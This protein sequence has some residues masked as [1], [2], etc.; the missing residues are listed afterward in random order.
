MNIRDNAHCGQ[1][2][3]RRI[4][5]TGSTLL[6]RSDVR[7]VWILW[8]EIRQHWRKLD[9]LGGRCSQPAI[10]RAYRSCCVYRL[11]VCTECSRQFKFS[12]ILLSKLQ[13][14]RVGGREGKVLAPPQKKMLKPRV[15]LFRSAVFM[16]SLCS[17]YLPLTS[18]SPFH[19]N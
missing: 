14:G 8:T 12:A 6:L 1:R 4:S 16:T 3:L 5:T 18:Y 15:A 11:S 2:P 13:L 17:P 7:W 10:G 9:R 19:V